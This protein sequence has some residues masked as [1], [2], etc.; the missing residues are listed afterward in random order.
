MFLKSFRIVLLFFIVFISF[1]C[2][3]KKEQ[4][5]DKKKLIEA[6]CSKCHNLDLPPESF[7]NEIAPPMMAV[8]F[9]V[10]G[11]MHVND[12]S[13]RIPKAIEF[14][15]EYVVHP[16]REKSL[17]DKA[18]L[19]SYGLMPSQKGNVSDDELHA[20]A[21]Y[22]FSHYTQKNLNEAQNVRNR[23]N[24]M[25]KGERLALKNNC[26]SCHR[27]DKKI[28]GPSLKDIAE[29]YKNEPQK[30][31]ESIKNGSSKKWNSSHGAVMP[32]FK[33]L[34]EEELEI[35]QKWILSLGTSQ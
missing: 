31:V 28:V 24:A 33:K 35:L 7:E 11:F 18:S 9:H 20:I 16:S 14:V 21:E 15:R 22:M 6:K 25:P 10:K 23:L 5:F 26:M 4:H 17:C 29:R 32:A 13:L 1:G 27:I 2:Q 34:S 12:E 30:L 8:A 3:E 19:A